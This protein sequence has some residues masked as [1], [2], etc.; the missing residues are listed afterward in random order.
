MKAMKN[1]LG[2]FLSVAT[3]SGCVRGSDGISKLD[4]FRDRFVEGVRGGGVPVHTQPEKD[5]VLYMT[6][7][8]FPEGYD[9]RRDTSFGEVQG[10]LVLFRDSVRVLEVPAGPGSTASLDP[11]LHHFVDGHIYT[12]SCTADGTV[13]GRDGETLFSYPGREL[14]CG[15]LVEGKDVYTLGRSRS[16]AGF[17]LRRNGEE[18]FSRPDGGIAAQYSSNP[19]YL[20]GALYRDRGHMYFSYW[21][22]LEE[23]S[24]IKLWYVVEDG[25]ES[26]VEVPDGRMYDIRIRDGTP[27]ISLI[28]SSPLGVYSYYEGSWKDVVAV[29]KE[30]RITVYAP[31]WPTSHYI[32]RRM[33]FL[34]FRNACLFGHRLYI[35]MNPLDGDERPFL[36]RDGET[37]Y[38]LDLN[39]F[40]TEVSAGEESAGPDDNQAR[41]VGFAMFFH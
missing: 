11:D 36:W 34:S 32:G 37:L 35:A 39:G 13:I 20:S 2:I 25:A 41:D 7:V 22:P 17:S 12:E 14:L 29:S 19:G 26:R 18:L 31:L 5:T 38:H 1:L 8:E 40:V 33:L 30:G 4:A 10:R 16:G 21:R 3:L 23:G 24:E 9:W 28:K 15:L 27:V 6:A